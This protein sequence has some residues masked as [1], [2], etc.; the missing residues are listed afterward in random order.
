MNRTKKFSGLGSFVLAVL[1]GIVPFAAPQACMQALQEGLVLCGGPLLLSLYPFL[2][3]SSLLIQCPLGDVLALP[4]R[5]VAWLVGVRASCAAR[6]LLIGFLGG[7]APAAN[8]SAEAVRSGQMTAKEADQLLPACICSGPSFVIL[9]VGQAL[10]GSA[11][12]GVLLF[13]AQ[14][15]AG[16]LCAAFLARLSQDKK[17]TRTKRHLYNMQT[18]DAAVSLKSWFSIDGPKQKNQPPVPQQNMP[19]PPKLR[20]D[21][22]LAQCTQTY[23]K[24]CGFVLF[25]R[26]LAAGAGALFPSTV[27]TACAI[28]LEVCSGC[29]LA[30]RTGY[31]AST[32][33]CAAL[34]IQ[35]VS[36]LLQVRTICPPSMTLRPLY[37][38]RLLHLPLSLAMFYLLLPDG[39]TE[40]FSTLPPRVILMRRLPPDCVLLLF[41]GCCIAACQLTNGLLQKDFQENQETSPFDLDSSGLL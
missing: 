32:L 10:L 29:D 24:L 38:A 39:E 30:A 33:C 3:V 17:L 1:I 40:V 25:F 15:S 35:G 19:C 31:W 27:G 4:F 23:L 11:E 2:V 22:I 14:L 9:T 41:L 36:V 28:L 37:T 26:M 18:S 6:V 7:F 8:A 5:P 16:Y 20:L 12:I 13:L 21:S 34:S